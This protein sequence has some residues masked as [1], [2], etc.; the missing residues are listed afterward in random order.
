MAAEIF[1]E[2]HYIKKLEEMRKEIISLKDHSDFQYEPYV[3]GSKQAVLRNVSRPTIKEYVKGTPITLE[4]VDGGETIIPLEKQSYF[5]FFE[6]DTDRAKTTLRIA[7]ATLQEAL[8]GLAVA[9]DAYVG[10]KIKS[11]LTT[12]KSTSAITISTDNIKAEIKRG[13]T[14]L[15]KASV[16]QTEKVFLEVI[17]EV[18]YELADMLATLKTNNDELLRH[19][20]LGEY[21]NCYISMENGLPT[22]STANNMYNFMRTKKAVAFY[23]TF[24]KVEQMRGHNQFRNE[25]RGLSIYGAKVMRPDE[26]YAIEVMLATVFTALNDLIADGEAL[27]EADYVATTWSVFATALAAAKV[28]AANASATQAQV[29][30]ALDALQDAI[31]GLVTFKAA[32]GTLIATAD[33]LKESDYSAGWSDFAT[34]LAAAKTAY[35]NESSTSAQLATALTNLTNAIEGLT[36]I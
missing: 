22:G 9:Q 35:N 3:K 2:V 11:S 10:G 25:Y 13:R 5:A 33:V 27:K 23:E 7:D 24:V 20:A 29:N 32:L 14:L 34:A 19:G 15:A 17:P 12:N 4:D 16:P 36:S 21:L 1:N 6:D 31:D 8:Q 26:V 28:V 30:S 18:Y